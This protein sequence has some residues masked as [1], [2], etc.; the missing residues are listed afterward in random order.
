MAGGWV[1]KGPMTV[2]AARK[3]GDA[4]R[5][6]SVRAGTVYRHFPTKQSLRE[7]IVLARV[8]GLAA[9]ARQLMAAATPQAAF[10]DFLSHVVEGAPTLP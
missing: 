3:A 8:E 7:A 6:R 10:V 1:K 4:S 5:N 9:H 2:L